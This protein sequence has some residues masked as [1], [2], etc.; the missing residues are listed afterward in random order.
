MPKVTLNEV[1]ISILN[2]LDGMNQE[3][4]GL[5]QLMSE[6]GLNLEGLQEARREQTLQFRAGNAETG[7]QGRN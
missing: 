4:E 6:A 1:L 7:I 2:P 5:K 3:W